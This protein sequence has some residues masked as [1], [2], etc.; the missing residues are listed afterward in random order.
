MRR[1]FKLISLISAAAI[2]AVSVA[3]PGTYAKPDYAKKEKQSCKYCHSTN[4]PSKENLNEAGKY[5][6]DHDHSL[7][8][9]QQK[10]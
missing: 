4:K 10:K 3:M 6:R 9:Y 7:K 1:W 2:L 5:Y 8:G